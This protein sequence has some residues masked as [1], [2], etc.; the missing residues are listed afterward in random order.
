MSILGSLKGVKMNNG[1]N[2]VFL[3]MAKYSIAT[4][5]VVVAIVASA[6][7]AVSKDTS[8]DNSKFSSL[9]PTSSAIGYGL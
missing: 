2:A 9:S 3:D 8:A 6:A 7:M 1:F 5:I 4:I